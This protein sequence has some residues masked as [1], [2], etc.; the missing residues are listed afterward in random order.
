MCIDI[1]KSIFYNLANEGVVLSIG[2]LRTLQVHYL[3]TAQD[4]LKR[5]EDDAAVNGLAF[6]RN[7][8]SEAVETFSNGIRQASDIILKDPFGAPLIPP[9]SRVTSAIPDFLERL[10]TAVE[11]DNRL[12]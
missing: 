7:A 8:E 2:V 9:W 10:Q 6:D 1:T 11:E 12:D 5:Y 3:R 4:T